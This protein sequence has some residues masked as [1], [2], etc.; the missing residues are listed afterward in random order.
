MLE[1]LKK[2]WFVA[3]VALVLVV[4]TGFY[5]TDQTKNTVKSKKVGGKQVV[6]TI[7]KDNYF[8]EDFQK[9]LD[10]NLGDSAIYQ[11]FRRELLTNL[12]SSDDIKSDAKFR[13]ESFITYIK[14]SEGQKGLDNLNKELVAMGYEGVDD[15]NTYYEN[16]LKYQSL[17]SD[18]FME[19]YDEVFKKDVEEN[20]PRLV[21]H[22]LVKI[23]DK[24][25][26]TEDE[27]AKIKKVEE[28]LEKGGN[29]EEVA[30]QHSEDTQS[31]QQGGSIGVV[32]KKSSLVKPFLD[33]MVTLDKGEVSDWV[34]SDYGKHIIK[35]D[36]TDFKKLLKDATYFGK[37]EEKHSDIVAKA[38]WDA[39]DTL[40]FKFANDEVETRIKNVIGLEKE[41]N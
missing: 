23:E 19:N 32:D 11:V 25:N 7:G 12:E 21:S 15:L 20:L 38:I 18:A 16:E 30:M 40:D 26:P 41:G 2:N 39:K 37:L 13:A 31:A 29:F 9:D 4:A 5:I 28:A 24:E 6:F 3:V 22:I 8:A 33:A 14:Q 35:V 36:E 10:E 17:I 1:Q 34:E 27:L